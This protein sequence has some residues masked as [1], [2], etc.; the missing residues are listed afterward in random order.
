MIRLIQHK[1]LIHQGKITNST[2]KWVS[3]LSA[4][5]IQTALREYNADQLPGG[6]FRLS[7][8]SADLQLI[9]NTV[10]ISS[11]L[12]LPTAKELHALRYSFIHSIL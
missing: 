3:G 8:Q 10:G 2:E 11:N 9:L 4:E 12:I 5:R 6:Y 1:I 7:K